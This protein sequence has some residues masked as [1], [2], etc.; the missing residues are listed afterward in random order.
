MLKIEKKSAVLKFTEI[1]VID[2]RIKDMYFKS[3]QREK[4]F[5]KPVSVL[6]GELKVSR[7]PYSVSH[8]IQKKKKSS[9]VIQLFPTKTGEGSPEIHYHCSK[10]KVKHF[11]PH[12]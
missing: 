7:V 2:N 1:P 10:L 6:T 5:N 4:K 11:T 3:K 12:L 8:Y 9:G